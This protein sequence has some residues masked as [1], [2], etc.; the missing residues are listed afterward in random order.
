[1]KPHFLSFGGS[2]VLSQYLRKYGPVSLLF[3]INKI[4]EKIVNDTLVDHVEKFDLFLI[5]CVAS[6]L[7]IQ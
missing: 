5:S 7:L 4:F 1:M 3:V 6:G 2:H